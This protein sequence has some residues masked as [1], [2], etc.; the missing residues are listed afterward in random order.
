M[1]VCVSLSLTLVSYNLCPHWGAHEWQGEQIP[2][3]PLKQLN[4]G[5]NILF[6][7]LFIKFYGLELAIFVPWNEWKWSFYYYYYFCKSAVTNGTAHK[8]MSLTPFLCRDL[9]TRAGKVRRERKRI[10]PL[11]LNISKW[12]ALLR[13]AHRED[14]GPNLTFWVSVCVHAGFPET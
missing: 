14:V 4:R 5:D 11:P 8:C 1:H 2:Q 3:Q 13:W 7:L 9:G 6:L 10:N 12:V